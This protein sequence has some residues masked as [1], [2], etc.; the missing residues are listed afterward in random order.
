MDESE[1]SR[2]AASVV[3]AMESD[4]ARHWIGFKGIAA[5]VVMALQR[6]SQ[7]R[8]TGDRLRLAAFSAHE[9]PPD[10]G[11]RCDELRNQLVAFQSDDLHSFGRELRRSTLITAIGILD[12]CLFEVLLFMVS[13]RPDLLSRM[14]DDSRK[15]K[16]DKDDSLTSAR[17]SLRRS[18]IDK[19]LKRVGEVFQIVVPEQLLAELSPLLE[20]RH[21]IT[22]RSKF[23]ETVLVDGKAILQAR[24]FPEVSYDE[25]VIAL[26][27]VTEIADCVLAGVAREYFCSDL[28]DLRPLNPAVA[29]FNRSMRLRIQENREKG[30]KIEIVEN[31]NWSVLVR[32]AGTFVVDEDRTI[33]FYPV[34]VL[35]YVISV[36]CLR[37]DVHGEKAYVAIDDGD[38]EEAD[39]M[40]ETFLARLLVGRSVLVEYQSISSDVPLYVRLSLKGFAAKWAEVREMFIAEKE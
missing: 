29:E 21:S 17:D 11:S 12:F 19:L 20:K 1:V 2:I 18:S 24:A 10:P 7:A 15:R 23:Y 38:K 34:D 37:H 3:S 36:H 22:H 31:P 9:I 25:S 27:T 30:P 33:I 16:N 28:G 26:I 5:S 40:G 32:D 35:N 14:P 4:E 8:L 39:F 6:A 13:T